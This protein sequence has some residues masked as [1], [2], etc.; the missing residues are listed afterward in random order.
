MQIADHGFADMTAE[1]RIAIVIP[2]LKAGEVAFAEENINAFPDIH[3]IGGGNN[4][5]T[6]GFEDANDL[7]E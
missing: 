1:D 4:E 3:G 7:F 6:S 2:F 5:N